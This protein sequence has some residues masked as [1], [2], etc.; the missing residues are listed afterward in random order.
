VSYATNRPPGM[1]T[2]MEGRPGA[3]HLCRGWSAFEGTRTACGSV[4]KHDDN[5][6]HVHPV[7]L[8]IFGK[9]LSKWPA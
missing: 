6:R 9:P 8:E 3:W 1:V 5:W 7:E 2:V 4:I